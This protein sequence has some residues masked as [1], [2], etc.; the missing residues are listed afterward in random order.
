MKNTNGTHDG[1]YW[2]KQWN[3]N[4]GPLVRLVDKIA[5]NV[6]ESKSK[7]HKTVLA[8]LESATKEMMDWMDKQKAPK[9][10]N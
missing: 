9:T 10:R 1:T 7:S 5:S 2:L 8:E 3:R 4:M 6:G